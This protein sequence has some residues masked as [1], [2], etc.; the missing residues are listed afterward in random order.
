MEVDLR[1]VY[2]H[3]GFKY[4]CQVSSFSTSVTHPEATIR[5]VHGTHIDIK[6][7]DDVKSLYIDAKIVHFIPKGLDLLF[8]NLTELWI[9]SCSL[10]E[11]SQVD[12]KGF[13]KLECLSLSLNKLK[14]LPDDLFDNKPHLK[15]IYFNG[16][17]L[18]FMSSKL[19][20]PIMK[21]RLRTVEFKGNTKINAFLGFGSAKSIEELMKIIDE[22]CTKPVVTQNSSILKK[23]QEMSNQHEAKL[24]EG[25]SKLWTT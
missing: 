21:N 13:E 5:D 24:F 20:E 1:V 25:F 15:E 7:N 23:K 11:I 9:I 17:Q 8:H 18:E 14:S 2:K 12:L 3:Y 16:N 10:K 6:T 22:E 19:L 4:S